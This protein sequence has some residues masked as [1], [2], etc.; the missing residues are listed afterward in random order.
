MRT[1]TPSEIETF[2]RDGIVKVAGA[3]PPELAAEMLAAV[4]RVLAAPEA[5]GLFGMDRRVCA[6][7][8][9]FASFL[10]R[11]GL[12][13]LAAQAMGSETIRIYFDQLF[14][15]EPNTEDKV[16]HWHQDHPFWP[17]RGEQVAS[18]WV[19]LTAATVQ[20]SALE[21]V[22]GSH[23]WGKDYRP[24]LGEG[25]GFEQMN[26]LW[27]GFGDHAASLTDIIDD[28]ELHPE[29]YDVVGFDVE[30]GD[31]LLFDY[32]IVHRSRGNSTDRRRVAVSWRWLG[33]SAVWAPIHGADPVISQEH[34]TLRPGDRITDDKAFPLV[35]RTAPIDLRQPV[36]ASAD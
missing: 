20:A 30:P 16:F 22:R 4:D 11:S 35:F 32:R 23:R 3:V 26:Q 28:F 8:E 2:R 5:T 21:F 7:D 31:A 13:A 12:A 17:I 36:P 1:L 34:T 29:R 6:R 27:D 24:F 14:V 19:A 9:Q 18:T 10:Y 25:V 15:K 33:D